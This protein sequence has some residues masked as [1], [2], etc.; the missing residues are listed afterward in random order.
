MENTFIYFNIQTLSETGPIMII[1]SEEIYNL[2][3]SC[4]FHNLLP[5]QHHR[6]VSGI[7]YRNFKVKIFKLLFWPF[8]TRGGEQG[9][10]LIE[11]LKCHYY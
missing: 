3:S 5:P 7:S 4:Y 9:V 11:K 8:E 2:L 1:N 6:W 10:N